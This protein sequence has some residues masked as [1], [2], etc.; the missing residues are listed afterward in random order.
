MHP[1]KHAEPFL[2][3]VSTSE[4]PMVQVDIINGLSGYEF[5][6]LRLTASVGSMVAWT[7]RTAVPQVVQLGDRIIH[8]APSR[9]DGATVITRLSECGEIVGRLSSNRRTS[10][11]FSVTEGS[12]V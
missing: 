11:T 9:N 4:D 12:D 6:R 1:K 2:V 7:N 8:L 3:L 5:S 10:I